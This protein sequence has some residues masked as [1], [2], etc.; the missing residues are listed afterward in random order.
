MNWR[1]T[2]HCTRLSLI[3]IRLSLRSS[4]RNVRHRRCV[5]VCEC[6]SEWVS[7]WER[8][9]YWQSIDDWRSVSTTPLPGDT[10]SGRVVYIC[11][12]MMSVWYIH[13]A[14]FI[15]LH[16]L[17][18]HIQGGCKGLINNISYMYKNDVGKGGR[19]YVHEAY[20]AKKNKNIFCYVNTSHWHRFYTY[21][22]YLGTRGPA[23]GGEY[24]TPTLRLALWHAFRQ[25]TRGPRPS[26]VRPNHQPALS[27]VRDPKPIPW[28][29][30]TTGGPGSSLSDIRRVSLEGKGRRT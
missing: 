20:E 18:E 17:H 1:H 21:I 4:E 29:P 2:Q 30:G 7:V 15:F 6:V 5:C 10:A 26:P 24:Y 3:P 19:V 11:I 25:H 22:Y 27:R 13:I 23:Y 16:R 8:K 14:K 12:K 9:V 28:P